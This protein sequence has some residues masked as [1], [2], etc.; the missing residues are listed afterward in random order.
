M[1]EKELFF[2][3]FVSNYGDIIKVDNVCYNHTKLA[4]RIVSNDYWL[5]DR[6]LESKHCIAIDFLIHEMG[7]LK[8][9]NRNKKVI[10]YSM[11]KKKSKV[12]KDYILLYQSLGYEIEM[13]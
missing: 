13:M 3:G 4:E 9:G 6:M 12:I 10:V 8:V 2:I 11:Y 7:Y 5:Q 1:N